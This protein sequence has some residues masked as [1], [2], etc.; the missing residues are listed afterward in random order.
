[1]PQAVASSQELAAFF[2]CRAIPA[3]FA[4]LCLRTSATT[5][6]PHRA[7]L[8]TKVKVQFERLVKRLSTPFFPVFQG[9]NPIQFQPCFPVFT[10]RSAEGRKAACNYRLRRTSFG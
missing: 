10:V 5:P 4:A 9:F 8:K 7:L 3:I 2:F 6:T 1:V